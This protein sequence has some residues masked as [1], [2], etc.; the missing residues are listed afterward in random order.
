MGVRAYRAA[1][2][3]LPVTLRTKH[4]EA[5]T[6]LF[7][8]EMQDARARG[9]FAELRTLA[10]AMTDVVRRAAYERTVLLEPIA[11]AGDATLP[12]ITARQLAR[13]LLVP[14]VGV[15][16][17]LTAAMLARY[18]TQHSTLPPL[19][20]LGLSVPFVAA[21][22]I[23]M[24]MFVAMLRVSRRLRREWVTAVIPSRIVRAV[25]LVSSVVA[26]GTGVLASE[27]VPR[28]NARLSR[29]LAGHEVARGDRAM[30]AGEL[31]RAAVVA[32]SPERKAGYGVELHKKFVL[33]ASCVVL[34]LIALIVGWRAPAMG[35]VGTLITS[36]LVFGGYYTSLMAAESLAE[37]LVLP[38][39]LA[40]WLGTGIGLLLVT[41]SLRANAGRRLAR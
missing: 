19:M 27:V 20:L 22:T 33:A 25:L 23:P 32:T 26:V 39:W 18:A 3:L 24:A 8:R 36:V 37:A 1:L 10:M 13:L 34:A 16:T 2:R 21:V 12:P 40:M 6:A 29:L 7:A 4:G 28:T 5:M 41:A 31:R 15:F 30:T 35:A 38:P 17:V 11:H 9:T 14:F